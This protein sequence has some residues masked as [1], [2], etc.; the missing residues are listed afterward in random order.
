MSFKQAILS[1]YYKNKLGSESESEN[2]SDNESVY[3]PSKSK[4]IYEQ[5]MSWTRVKNVEQAVNQR[6]MIFDVEQDLLTDR[7]LK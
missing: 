4:R 1:N 2:D 7:N 3:L 5:P 6:A